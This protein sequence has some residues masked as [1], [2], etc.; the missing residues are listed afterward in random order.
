M[1]DT[2]IS[3]DPGK[4]VS[5]YILY[6]MSLA[7]SWFGFSMIALD[8]YELWMKI[9]GR[10]ITSP[11]KDRDILIRRM[12]YQLDAYK[13]EQRY[14]NMR[15]IQRLQMMKLQSDCRIRLLERKINNHRLAAAT[16]T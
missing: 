13:I 5:E 3:A 16:S 10:K 7:G 2:V 6:L 1:P 11:I 14:Q 9:K 15:V 8:P 12:K 4:Y